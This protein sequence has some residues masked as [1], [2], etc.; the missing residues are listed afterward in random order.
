MSP[1]LIALVAVA[2]MGFANQLGD[3]CTVAAITEIVRVRRF[4]RLI[5]LLEAALWAGVSLLWLDT[6]DALSVKPSSY[7]VGL[8]TILGGALFGLGALLN[9]ACV[10]GTV[11][12]LGNGEWAYVFTPAGIYLG[13]LIA[14]EFLPSQPLTS[15]EAISFGSS[16]WLLVL[17]I[18][19][20]LIRLCVHRLRRRQEKQ[21]IF[22]YMCSPSVATTLIGISFVAA[23][24]AAGSWSYAEFLGD[25]ARGDAQALPTKWTLFAVLMAG[26]AWGAWINGQFQSITPTMGNS[27]R[28][29]LGGTLMGAGAVLIP[30]GNISLVLLG[31][32]LLQPYAWVAFAS[33]CITLYAAIRMTTRSDAP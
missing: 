7:A 32:P 11:S 16:P 24:A 1:F 31:M 23:F 21:T 3:T 20:V 13:S 18:G 10:F 9:R 25:F 33:T 30:G 19:L 17:T 12:R 15:D 8:I 4:T 2:V 22:R 14:L 5:A 27:I 6:F 26:S 28:C 29:L